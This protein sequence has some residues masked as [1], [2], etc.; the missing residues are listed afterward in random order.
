MDEIGKI[1]PSLFR[2]QIRRDQPRL[3]E[4]MVPFWPS[5]VG[6]TMAEHSRP[7]LFEAGVLTLA[8]DGATWATQLGHLTEEICAGINAF[9]GVPVVKKLRIKSVLQP[10]LFASPRRTATASPQAPKE[11][12]PMDTTAIVDPEVA[13][14]LATSHAKYF[15]RPRR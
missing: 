7:A 9:L 1:L 5:I 6:R 14:A 3:L 10:M 15:G 11:Q 8:A 13:T 2:K 4:I 12:L